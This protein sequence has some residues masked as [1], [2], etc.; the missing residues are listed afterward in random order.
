MSST[1]IS[2]PDWNAEIRM[3]VRADTDAMVAHLQR[4]NRQDRV[5]RFGGQVSDQFLATYASM[6]RG[7]HTSALGC[8]HD[9]QMI[10][11][12]QLT[13]AANE[14]AEAAMT[15]D[16]DWRDQGVGTALLARLAALS[17]A[18]S[19]HRLQL[20]CMPLNLRLIHVA[21]KFGATLKS[22]SGDLLIE[23][24]VG[25]TQVRDSDRQS[26]AADRRY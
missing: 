26:G 20:L 23:F 15:V 16:K 8:F 14:A 17:A 12:G 9:G 2:R 24:S 7:H 1:T 18:A 11:L 22:R 21:R 5:R 13:L 3:L 6:P 19:A 4:L 25:Q 10:G